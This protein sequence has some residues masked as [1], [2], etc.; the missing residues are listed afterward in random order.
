MK[1]RSPLIIVRDIL[2]VLQCPRKVSHVVRKAN[3]APNRCESYLGKLESEG[4]ITREKR[5]GF[6]Y[7]SRTGAGM[8][9]LNRLSDPVMDGGDMIDGPTIE[10]ALAEI[11]PLLAEQKR[12]YMIDH[13]ESIKASKKRWAEKDKERRRLARLNNAANM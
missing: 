12:R 10:E 8:A 2:L 13:A 7:I 11:T 4:L 1:R 5:D 6:V 9:V 3:L